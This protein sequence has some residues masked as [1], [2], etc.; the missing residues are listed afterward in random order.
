MPVIVYPVPGHYLNG[1]PAFPTSVTKAQ[2]ERLIRT[3]AFT[4]KGESEDEPLTLTEEGLSNLAYYD[5][6]EA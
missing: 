4:D 3:G 6:Q 5:H 2:A 1:I